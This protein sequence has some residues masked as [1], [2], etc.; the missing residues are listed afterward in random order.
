MW[1]SSKKKKKVL[2]KHLSI[3]GPPEYGALCRPEQPNKASPAVPPVDRPHNGGVLP[4]RRPREGARHGDKSDVWQ[5]QCICGKITGD[6][7][8][9][10]LSERTK[11]QFERLITVCAHHTAF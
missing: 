1:I 7:L 6:A 9:I 10:E 5:A 2:K 11:L 4:P 8:S 3:L